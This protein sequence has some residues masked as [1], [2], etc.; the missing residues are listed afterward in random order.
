MQCT[1]PRARW[2]D[3]AAAA[4]SS[5]PDISRYILSTSIPYT[6]T[7]STSQLLP[8]I[9]CLPFCFGHIKAASSAKQGS[10][11]QQLPD[12]VSGPIADDL[13]VRVQVI[14]PQKLFIM[15]TRN[16]FFPADTVCLT[17][18]ASEYDDIQHTIHLQVGLHINQ[19]CSHRI[20]CKG[21]FTLGKSGLHD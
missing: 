9:S 21:H 8:C 12:I 17:D 5:I 13:C 2:L 7:C 6:L 14:V 15:K 10:V 18:A 3:A 16:S 11:Y 20:H 1:E 4:H 19:S